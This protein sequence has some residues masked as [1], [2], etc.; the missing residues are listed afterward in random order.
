L[1]TTSNRIISANRANA[2]ASTGPKT[3]HGR[4]RSARNAFRHGLSLPIYSDPVLSEE[5]EALAR[6]I[7]GKYANFEIL[8]LARR[9]AEA[10][11]DLRR[12]RDA[13]HRLLSE[14]LSR[15]YYDT[16]AT[17][18][19]KFAVIEQPLMRPTIRRANAG[20]P[21]CDNLSRWSADRGLG[22]LVSRCD[23]GH[24]GERISKRDSPFCWPKY[25]SQWSAP[26]ISGPP[27]LEAW[28]QLRTRMRPRRRLAASAGRSAAVSKQI[29]LTLKMSLTSVAVAHRIWFYARGG[30]IWEA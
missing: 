19:E 3:T 28:P 10:Q 18:P 20:R 4:I 21:S 24:Q 29:G 11:I 27:P 6:E 22:L 2:R 16:Q 30:K 12:V 5:L 13:R 23:S 14:A 9:V 25:Y 8:A 15:P 26:W 17:L 1:S 7:A